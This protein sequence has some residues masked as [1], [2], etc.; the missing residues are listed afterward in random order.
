MD[1]F[2]YTSGQA[3]RLD[4]NTIP[5][6]PGGKGGRESLKDLPRIPSLVSIELGCKPRELGLNMTGKYRA[7]AQEQSGCLVNSMWL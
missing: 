4:L 5:L 7:R 2:M 1:P 3:C 6:V